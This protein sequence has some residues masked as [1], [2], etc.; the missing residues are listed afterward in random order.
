MTKKAMK[1]SYLH[2][3]QTSLDTLASFQ[4][5]TQRTDDH[6]EALLAFKEKRLPH[7]KSE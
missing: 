2:D 6:F 7:F 4:G 3:L 5:I 1:I